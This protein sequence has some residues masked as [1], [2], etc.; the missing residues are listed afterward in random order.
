M[1]GIPWNSI[2]LFC[3]ITFCVTSLYKAF[4]L[5]MFCSSRGVNRT[6]F[7]GG[8]NTTVCT[9][10]SLPKVWWFWSN[11]Y[12]PHVLSYCCWTSAQVKAL[13]QSG[14]IMCV[15]IPHTPIFPFHGPSCFHENFDGD[16]LPSETPGNPNSIPYY[17]LHL[18]ASLGLYINL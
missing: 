11:V 2:T 17:C 4:M 15:A 1:S 12:G 3:F 14:I 7:I 16:A 5:E 18:L 13:L 6:N 8:P 10:L 9:L